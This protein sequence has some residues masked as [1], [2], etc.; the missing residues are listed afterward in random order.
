MSA[1]ICPVQFFPDSIEAVPDRQCFLIRKIGIHDC[2]LAGSCLSF[3]CHC[4]ALIHEFAVRNIRSIRLFPVFAHQ[5]AAFRY[6]DNLFRGA[7]AV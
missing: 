6:V 5:D 4:D 3:E 7:A 1:R 2:L